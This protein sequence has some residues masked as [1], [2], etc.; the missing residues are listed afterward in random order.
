[1]STTIIDKP[2][3]GTMPV[4]VPK[5]ENR[6]ERA[7][8]PAVAKRVKTASAESADSYPSCLDLAADFLARG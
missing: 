4:A 1:M 8:I 7:T 5:N 2:K 3:A 6:M